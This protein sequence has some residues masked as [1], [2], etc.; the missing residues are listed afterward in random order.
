M[1]T[2]AE[3]QELIE[4]LSFLPGIGRKTAARLALYLLE[5]RQQAKQISDSIDNSLAKVDFCSECGFYKSA[6]QKLCRI[7][8]NDKRAKQQLM[9]VES[10]L[11]VLA[12]EETDYDGLYVVLHG[13]ISP[14]EGKGPDDIRIDYLRIKLGQELSTGETR[15]VIFA[16][17]TSLEGEATAEYLKSEVKK[18]QGQGQKI[19]MVRIA[20][21]LPQNSGIDYQDRGTLANSIQNRLEID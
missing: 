9:V 12:I 6:D 18:F 2:P 15:E 17:P 21:G 1:N 20:T 8:S 11:D 10:P 5:S 16:L 4:S 19:K 13:L 7:C 14:L 3:V